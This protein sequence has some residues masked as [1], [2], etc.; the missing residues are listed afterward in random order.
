MERE[1]TSDADIIRLEAFQK[2]NIPHGG[3]LEVYNVPEFARIIVCEL[4]PRLAR[5][6]TKN[7][8]AYLVLAAFRLHDEK[9]DEAS[10]TSLFSAVHLV[11]KDTLSRSHDLDVLS[12]WL[13]NTWRLFNLLR[14]YGGDDRN[15]EWQAANTEQQ[16]SYRFKSYDVTPI[17]DQLK[18]RVE[19]SYTA[20]MKRAV[21]HVLSPKIVPAVLQHESSSD[22]MTSGRERDVSRVSNGD[23]PRRGLDDL[24]Q[25][26]DLVHTKLVTYGADNIVVGQVIGQMTNWMCALSL[27]HLMFRKEL[28]NFEKA[29]QIKHNVTEI[30]NWLHSKGLGEFREALEPLVQA[31]H[32]LQSRKDESNL[33][34]LCGEMTS[35]LKPRQVVAILQHYDPSDDMEEGITPQF[36][37]A[38]QRKLNER[39]AKNND[40]VEDKDALIMMG[41]YLPPFDT[42][43]FSYSDFP[44]ETLSLPSCLHLNNVCRLV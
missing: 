28:C 15:P 9:R 34:T 35:K 31:C 11:L 38:V 16:N 7:L 20:L 5:L 25:F 39:A 14:Q 40:P 37:V 2:E 4:K 12:L 36:L 27:N 6:L 13:V 19:E 44:L 21:E 26:L 23:T 10:L 1:N 41:T 17:R 42:R 30:Q 8:P 24:L 29:I 18:L 33:D 32:L 22:L 3:L 43:S